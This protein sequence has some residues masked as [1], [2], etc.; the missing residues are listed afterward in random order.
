MSFGFSSGDLVERWSLNFSEI[1]FVNSI[2]ELAQL[3]FAI[4]LKFFAARFLCA[5][6]CGDPP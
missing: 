4:Q 1:A 3:G 2:P 6:S 5:G